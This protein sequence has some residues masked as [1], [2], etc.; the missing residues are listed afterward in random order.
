MDDIERTTGAYGSTNGQNGG[1]GRAQDET[2]AA[3]GEATHAVAQAGRRLAEAGRQAA[4]SVA[5]KVKDEALHQK[6][7]ATGSVNRLADGLERVASDCSSEDRWAGDLLNAGAASLKKA[8]NYLSSAQP[9]DLLDD[10]ERLARRN[11]TAFV[12]ISLAAG[13]MLARFSKLAAERANGRRRGDGGFSDQDYASG[14][15]TTI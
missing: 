2:R 5:G 15:G 6:E 10:V 14:F 13:F 11:P 9:D 1:S 3:V 4:F 7:Q 8:A 12:A